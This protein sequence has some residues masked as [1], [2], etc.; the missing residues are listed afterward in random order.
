MLL[1]CFL[2]QKKKHRYC[3][4]AYKIVELHKT[5]LSYP[6]VSL[7]LLKSLFLPRHLPPLQQSG[8]PR[9]MT[10]PHQH[11]DKLPLP[12]FLPLPF[13][14]LFS[15]FGQHLYKILLNTE[16]FFLLVHFNFSPV[17]KSVSLAHISID[18]DLS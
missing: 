17:M 18:C 12:K 16:S 10:P 11:K 1:K 3:I 7:F 2:K 13:R 4:C 6:E 5:S 9:L 15:L 14:S 8:Y